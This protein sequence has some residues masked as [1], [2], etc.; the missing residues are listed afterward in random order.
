MTSMYDR[1][2]WDELYAL[3]DCVRLHYAHLDIN[4]MHLSNKYVDA[5]TK[6]RYK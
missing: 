6:I 5:D 1:S 4:N 2:V 3:F